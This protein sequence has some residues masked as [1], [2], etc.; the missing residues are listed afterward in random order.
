LRILQRGDAYRPK[1]GVDLPL[2]IA[3]T[4]TFAS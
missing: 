4:L 2:E 1:E 3:T